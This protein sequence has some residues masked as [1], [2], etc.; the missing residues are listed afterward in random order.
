MNSFDLFDT[1]IGRKCGT[2]S[3]LFEIMAGKLEDPGFV[4]KRRSAERVLQDKHIEYTLEDIYEVYGRKDLAKAEWQLELENVF[5]IAQTVRLLRS[6]DIIVSDMYLGEERL[7]ILLEKA[8]ISFSGKIYVSCYGKKDGSVWPEI[9]K[10]HNI[11]VHRGD[12]RTTDIVSPRP[13]GIRGALIQTG[14]SPAE[15]VYTKYSPKLAAWVRYHRLSQIVSEVNDRL[16]FL[17]IEYNVPFLWA[18]CGMLEEYRKRNKV[19]KLLFMSRDCQLLYKMF[20]RLYPRIQTEY[21]YISR[22]ALRKGSESFMSYLNDRY[23]E[24]VALVDLSA[25]CGS[26]KIALPKLHNKHPRIFTAIFLAEP[27][28]VELGPIEVEWGTTNTA[29]HINNTFVEMLNYGDH[30]HVKDVV[31]GQPVYDLPDEY[32]MALVKEYHAVVDRM[33]ED[34]P[35]VEGDTKPIFL[36]AIEGIQGER[37]YLARRF[38]RHI[39]LERNRKRT[40]EFARPRDN[41]IVVGAIF[42]VRWNSIVHWWKSLIATGFN[43]EIHMMCYDI[44]QPTRN[45]LKQNKIIVHEYRLLGTQVVIDRFRDLGLL[46]KSFNPKTWVLFA[47][48]MDIAFQSNPAVFL[49]TVKQNL[50]A[51][52]EGVTFEGNT[53]MS[54]NLKTAYPHLCETLRK[55]FFYNAGSLAG[56]ADL[57]SEFADAVYRMSTEYAVPGAISHDQTAA[58]IL[59]QGQSFKSQTLFLGPN[60]LWCFCGASSMFAPPK[61]AQNYQGMPVTVKNGLCYVNDH[62]MPV[63]FHHYT[64]DPKVRQAVQMRIEKHYSAFTRR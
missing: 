15:S 49:S 34:I 43:G 16:N 31:D 62:Q 28:R 23:T 1:L 42:N 59:L 56:K 20:S 4:E 29:T 21:I 54:N 30:L 26:L 6:T 19:K 12:N 55:E 22:D 58:N 44:D 11:N 2:A 33:L 24:N 5:P 57:F 37:N 64:R 47:D 14:Y 50:V 41:T 39:S 3:N 8:G 52:H 51:V 40:I 7:R 18:I 9:R 53:W 35:P 13:H 32:D 17:Q 45:I 36:R 60:D 10:T 46:L 63:M 61:D 25:S 48:V 27:F 38:P